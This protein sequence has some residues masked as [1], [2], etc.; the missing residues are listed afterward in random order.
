[1]YVHVCAHRGMVM[2]ACIIIA[3]IANYNDKNINEYFVIDIPLSGF[4]PLS[5]VSS[6]DFTEF[7]LSEQKIISRIHQ[8]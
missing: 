8:K 5:S 2:Y 6:D 7:R 3:T 1:M 4:F